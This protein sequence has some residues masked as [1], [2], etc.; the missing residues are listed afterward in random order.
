VVETGAWIGPDWIIQKG[1]KAGDKVIVD[2][3]LKLRPGTAVQLQ[4]AGAPA[5]KPGAADKAAPPKSDTP[6]D[7]K[8][9]G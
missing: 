1:L 4:A 9:G 6:A 7:A 3:L 5:P 2:N 8:K